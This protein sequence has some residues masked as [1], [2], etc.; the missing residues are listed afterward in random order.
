MIRC[1][2]KYSSVDFNDV[3]FYH[4]SAVPGTCELLR[5]WYLL[6]YQSH[7]HGEHELCKVMTRRNV[8]KSQKDFQIMKRCGLQANELKTREWQHS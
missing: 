1:E 7:L 6:G 4:Y 3:L 5:Q 8:R 2:D